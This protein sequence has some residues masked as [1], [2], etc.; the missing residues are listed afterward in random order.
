MVHAP[1][2]TTWAKSDIVIVTVVHSV[3]AKSATGVWPICSIAA[4]TEEYS[5]PSADVT[6]SVTDAKAS[7]VKAAGR[8]SYANIAVTSSVRTDTMK[9]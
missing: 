2:K 3:V 4:S 7:I 8:V 5:A 1:N 6:F 9:L